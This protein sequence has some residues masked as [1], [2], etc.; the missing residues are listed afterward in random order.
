MQSEQ[1]EILQLP[2]AYSDHL[3]HHHDVLVKFCRQHMTVMEL[4]MVAGVERVI[5]NVPPEE[6]LSTSWEAIMLPFFE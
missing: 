4:L 6:S 2:L 1:Q 3:K 5:K